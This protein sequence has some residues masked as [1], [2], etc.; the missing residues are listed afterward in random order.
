MNELYTFVGGYLLA[1]LSALVIQW[2]KQRRESAEWLRQERLK[3]HSALLEGLYSLQY[4]SGVA[5]FKGD[6]FGFEQ[7]EDQPSFAEVSRLLP[8]VRL[9]CTDKAYEAAI[10]AFERCRASVEDGTVGSHV[11]AEDAINRYLNAVRSEV[12]INHKVKL[13][14]DIMAD[15]SEPETLRDPEEKG[16]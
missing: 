8:P 15:L 13:S 14:E 7:V 9:V 1:A 5:N 11:S 10:E 3:A 16:I 6:E 4:W 2:M 12:K